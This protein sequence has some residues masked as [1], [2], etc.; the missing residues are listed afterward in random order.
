MFVKR[1]F[2]MLLAAMIISPLAC[3]SGE[4]I[5][6][7]D[8][9]YKAVGGPKLSASL[10][11]SVLE[12]GKV[13]TI[14]LRLANE[15][16]VEEMIP[17]GIQPGAEDEAFQEMTEELKV[18]DALGLTAWIEAEPPLRVLSGPLHLESL[19]SGAVVPLN[20]SLGV[21]EGAYGEHELVLVLSYERQTDVE[22][23]DGAVYP[24]Y[25]PVNSSQRLMLTLDGQKEQFR[26]EGVTSSLAPGGEGDLLVMIK[27]CG[28]LAE[29]CTA[30]LLAV[31]PLRTS[32][33]L[34]S[35]G[36]MS[37]GQVS[38]ARFQA[39]VDGNASVGQF[40]LACQVKTLQG[41]HLISIPLTLVERKG[42][43][44]PYGLGVVIAALIALSV[45]ARI[46]KNQRAMRMRRHSRPLK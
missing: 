19:P 8:D 4:I 28:P 32:D 13:T 45:Y 23:S 31:P 2:L 42:S 16:R 21:E 36:N 38:A 17:T 43:W 33:V 39:R 10:A 44:W 24:L 25:Q 3:C 18:A 20:F 26:V 29:N 1:A 6:F 22:V 15:G 5:Y 30:R 37:P 9:H 12:P 7:A 34:F 11:S 14:R 35:L 46:R 27:N 41:D 40:L